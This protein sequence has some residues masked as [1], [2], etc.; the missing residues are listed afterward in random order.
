[1]AL[2]LTTWTRDITIV[3][4]GRPHELDE[5]DYDAKRVMNDIALRTDRVR[6]VCC[7]GRAVTCLEFENGETL[8]TDK[9]FF[10]IAQRPADDIGVHLGC[11]R[12][13]GGHILVSEH[14]ATS[15]RGVFAAGDITPGP[16][17]A[18]RAAAAGA[19]A[20]LA[21]HKSLLPVERTLLDV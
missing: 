6:R 17:L 8:P 7:E 9:V 14:G 15:V 16:Q 2:A 3:S 11:D 20:A 5:D 18:V 21:M 4:N 10:T 13:R 12:D 1:M 19:V